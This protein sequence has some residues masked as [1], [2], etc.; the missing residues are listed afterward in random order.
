MFPLVKRLKLMIRSVMLFRRTCIWHPMTRSSPCFWFLSSIRASH[1][2][3][4]SRGSTSPLRRYHISIPQHARTGLIGVTRQ[5]SI[6]Y[7]NLPA[8]ILH[9]DTIPPLYP[10]CRP[11]KPKWQTSS[12]FLRRRENRRDVTSVAVPPPAIGP[13]CWL[14]D[15]SIRELCLDLSALARYSISACSASPR[16]RSLLLPRVSVMMQIRDGDQVRHLCILH[17]HI[18]SRP[19][20]TRRPRPKTPY[21]RPCPM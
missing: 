4:P 5:L 2:F 6:L 20:R 12:A 7:K 15:A 11:K 17:F 3:S 18:C 8:S 14:I 1:D 10:T 19:N 9:H 16:I 13:S 21:A